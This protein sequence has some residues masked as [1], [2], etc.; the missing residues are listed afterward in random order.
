MLPKTVSL[1]RKKTEPCVCCGG[2]SAVRESMDPSDLQ[3]VR[4][5]QKDADVEMDF[6]ECHVCGYGW[7]EMDIQRPDTPSVVNVVHD[8]TMNLPGQPKNSTMASP[9][10][11]FLVTAKPT[12]EVMVDRLGDIENWMSQYFFPVIQGGKR[13]PMTEQAFRDELDRRFEERRAVACN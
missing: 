7:Y 4:L 12:S 1:S 2:H 5:S 8:V 13:K 3:M 10:P 9:A 6:I 11:S